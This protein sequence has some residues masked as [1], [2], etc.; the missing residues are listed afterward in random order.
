MSQ[1]FV[2]NENPLECYMQQ[3]KHFDETVC[4]QEDYSRGILYTFLERCFEAAAEQ[5]WKTAPVL[6]HLGLAAKTLG[7]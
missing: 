6:R 1:L 4:T 2:D 5:G 3:L 7:N